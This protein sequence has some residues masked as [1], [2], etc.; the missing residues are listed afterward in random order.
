M[1]ELLAQ[2]DEYMRR[3]MKLDSPYDLEQGKL[4][5]FFIKKHMG[6]ES[7]EGVTEKQMIAEILDYKG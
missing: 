4:N 6:A 2:L 5:D 7:I 3:L 1:A